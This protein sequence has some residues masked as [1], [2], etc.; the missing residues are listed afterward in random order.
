MEYTSMLVRQVIDRITRTNILPV[1]EKYVNKD[2][3]GI[4]LAIY[5]EKYY[6]KTFKEALR[7]LKRDSLNR[8][9]RR[10]VNS[11]M[12]NYEAKKNQKELNGEYQLLVS[13]YEKFGSTAFQEQFQGFSTP[14]E[15]IATRIEELMRW[16]GDEEKY[17][18][19]YRYIHE[20]TPLQIEKAL[21]VD[22][23]IFIG[24]SLTDE[25]ISTP[26][27]LIIESPFS[28]IVHPFFGNTRGKVKLEQPIMQDEG[29]EYF[30][31]TYDSGDGTNYQFLIAKEYADVNKNRV[32]DLDR[33]DYKIFLEVMSKRDER[34]AS[35]KIIEVKV[36]DIVDNLYK[37]D[38]SK[39]YKIVEE[40]IN[41]MQYFRMTRKQEDVITS[42]GIFDFVR[43]YTQPS[44]TRVAEIHVNEV[45][46]HDYIQQQTVRIY[47]NKVEKLHL[48]S[49]F[50]LLFALQKERLYCYE[51]K[52]S[53]EVRLN[54]LYFATKVRFKK[55]RKVENLKEIE[56]A[57]DELVQQKIAVQSYRR[58]GEVFWI[59]FIPVEENEVRNL[60]EGH[61][62]Y[63]PIEYS[64]HNKLS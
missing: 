41:K 2:L 15:V 55:R 35:R 32:T 58:S 6:G 20:K 27:E 18:C 33:L 17:L 23:G 9:K 37:T 38:G 62:E 14:E 64:Q 60:L 44:G 49:S 56:E 13:Y 1:Y 63:L 22:I 29:K 59:Q 8:T 10:W 16:T 45:I 57:L 34:F 3:E 30:L 40:R 12:K 7:I 47:K 46:Y 53:Y 51:S 4:I 5:E 52:T 21:M 24:M 42:Y 39:N 54:Y 26:D 48:D 19:D 25:T 31:N 61:Y 36:G 50:H 11:T 28:T 43:I